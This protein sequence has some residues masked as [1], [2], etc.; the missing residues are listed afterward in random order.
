MSAGRP[1]EENKMTWAPEFVQ[2]EIDY[3]VERAHG[4][5]R[6]TLE[7]VRAAQDA[8]P[9]WWRRHRPNR[10]DEPGNSRAA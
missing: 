7:H 6:T 3:R 2:T 1:D 10:N 9:S 4:D 8:H 5:P